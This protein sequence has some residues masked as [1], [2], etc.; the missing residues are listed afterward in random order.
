MCR[1]ETLT[2]SLAPLCSRPHPVHQQGSLSP[3]AGGIQAQPLSHALPSGVA[4]SY[5]H[6]HDCLSVGLKASTLP[7]SSSLPPHHSQRV[8]Q[9]TVL[10][11]HPLRLPPTHSS[12]DTGEHNGPGDP[13]S[14]GASAVS[15]GPTPY[16]PELLEAPSTSQAVSCCGDSALRFPVTSVLF[17][18]HLPGLALLL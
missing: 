3:P 4:V 9:V 13:T 15:L 16:L 17:P 2:L 18:W 5:Q 12:A 10:L 14:H 7:S 8:L 1:P 11:P 6:F